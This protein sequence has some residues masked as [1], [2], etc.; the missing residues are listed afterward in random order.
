MCAGAPVTTGTRIKFCGLTRDEDSIQVGPLGGSYAGV[1]FAGGPRKVSLPRAALLL[2][3]VAPGVKKVGVFGDQSLDEIGEAVL[4]AWLHVVQLHND[5]TPDEVARTREVTQCEVWAVVRMDDPDAAMRR[6]AS[7]DGVA[8]AILVDSSV[9]GRFGGSG[10][11][12]DWDAFT[13][14]MRPRKSALAV[15]G[16]LTP[17]NVGDAIRALSPDIVDVSS[18]VERTRGIKDHDRMRAFA[19]AVRRY[20]TKGR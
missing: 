17:D 1:I 7:L 2:S 11:M 16:G 6:I 10:V 3:I 20:E 4:R 5:A 12:F 14:D 18:G 19:D 8:D 9:P 15:A 13:P